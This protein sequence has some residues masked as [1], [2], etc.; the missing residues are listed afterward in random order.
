MVADAVRITGHFT[1]LLLSARQRKGIG[2]PLRRRIMFMLLVVAGVLRELH[3]AVGVADRLRD[4]PQHMVILNPISRLG[5][6]LLHA[7]DQR[8]RADQR[9]AAALLTQGTSLHIGPF[10]GI[11]VCLVFYFLLKYTSFGFRTRMLGYNPIAARYA[12]VNSKRQMVIIMVIG[13][14]LGGLA[15]TIECIGLRHRLYMEYVTNVGYE[16]VAVALVAGGNP[17]GVLVSALFFSILK[18]GGA[19][20]AIETGVSSSMSSIIIALCV[21][22][23]VGVGV[24]DEKSASARKRKA[25]AA[26]AA[27]KEVAE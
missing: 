8:T 26:A 4:R 1:L 10:I 27:K 22:F 3:I 24:A 18:A 23:V 6:V 14:M 2:I 21:L 19:T 13:A 5:I 11:V 16:S 25:K 17:I 15:G 20:M 7:V 9:K 12:G